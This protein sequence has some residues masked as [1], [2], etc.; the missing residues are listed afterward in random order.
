MKRTLVMAAAAAAL[1]A[2]AGLTAVPAGA[3]GPGGTAPAD[4]QRASVLVAR[5]T[6]D[7]K[8][9]E[10]H[11]IQDSQHR[12]YVPG[13]PRLGIPPLVVTNGPA[14]AGPGDDPVQQPATALPAPISLAATWDPAA[15]ERYG[16]LTGAESADL[17]ATL[18]EGPDINI[19]RV[20]QN[21]RTFEAY[22]EDP[23]LVGRMAVANIRGI[24]RQGE[25]A[26]V[27]HYAANNQ[28]TDRFTESSVVDDRTLHEIYLPAFEASVTEGHAGAVMCSYPKVNGVYACENAD[29]LAGTLRQDWAFSGF[30]TSDFGAT[31]STVPSALA[32]LDLEMPTGVYFDSAMK[33]AIGSGR[34]GMGTIDTML[35]R[36]FATMMEFGLFDRPPVTRPIP[37]RQDGAAARAL[38]EEGTVLLKNAPAAGG[39]SP[40]LPLDAARIHSIAV[41]GPYAG[42][43]ATGGGGSS[44]VVPLY[45]V[46]PVTGIRDR[47]GPG[48][49]VTYA[50]GSDPAAAAAAARAADVALVMV[51]D[52]ETEGRDRPGLA[53]DGNQ[54]Q[55]VSAVAAANPR[56]VVVVKSGAPV[57]M[58]WAD[59]VPG[60][61][62]AWYPGEEDGNAVAAVLFGDTDPSGRLPITF[63]AKAGDVPA[64]T[65]AQYPGVGGQVT[66]SEGLDVGYRHYD[67]AGIAPLFPFGYGLSYTTFAFSGLRVHPDGHDGATVTA[68]VTN[69]GRR[70]G[71]EV[72][73]LYVG[74]P[75]SAA[76]P[77]PADQ[78]KGFARVRLAPGQ[79]RTV[80]FHLTARSFAYWDTARHSHRVAGGSYALRV[81]GSSRDLPLR[82]AVRLAPADA[83]A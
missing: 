6:L 61:V 19:A 59:R 37:A 11:G 74:D 10:L 45:T 80:T 67:D 29:L 52:Q 8:I 34:I 56:T 73:Q 40:V 23:Y 33:D 16:A 12:R 38:A 53:L 49:T 13:I 66:Y 25:I 22:G 41:I 70:A 1:A 14:G 75:S 76:L 27:K 31:H 9:T 46:D 17:G 83:G 51:G 78:L 21:G 82:T 15:A 69:T 58:P 35:T 2:L 18:V 62:E 55:V 77:E 50:D 47:V 32:G 36:R 42:A 48:T 72:A 63:P 28:E 7:E 81:G 44:H 3:T 5:M 43:A 24:Q 65:P 68:R 57:L 26:D 79:S 64:N 30:V 54:D 39:R 4:W 20:P 71:T 60:I